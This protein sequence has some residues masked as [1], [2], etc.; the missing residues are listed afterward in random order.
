MMS[1]KSGAHCTR[2]MDA[3]QAT[4]RQAPRNP[5]GTGGESQRPP[6]GAGD[7]GSTG[8][9][10]QVAGTAGR[11]HGLGTDSLGT[12]G[13]AGKTVPCMQGLTVSGT[14]AAELVG[15]C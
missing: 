9:I 5:V 14:T 4:G 8:P 6:T 2:R 7:L 1:A 13:K 3:C 15:M 10:Q 11:A 12:E